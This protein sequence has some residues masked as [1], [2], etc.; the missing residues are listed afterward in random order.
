MVTMIKGLATGGERVRMIKIAQISH[1]P[2]KI[3]REEDA[4]ALLR[5]KDSLHRHGILVPLTVRPWEG[6][7]RLVA[8]ERRL[9]AARELGFTEVPCVVFP[10][11]DRLCAEFALIESIHRRELDMFSQAE[12]INNLIGTVGL[13]RE[14][15][16]RQLSCS[17]GCISNKLRLLRFDREER[18]AI[19]RGGLTER[20]ARAVLRLGDKSARLRMIERIARDGMSVSRTEELVEL[21]LSAAFDAVDRAS[22]VRERRFA[23][24]TASRRP[25]FSWFC[26][27]FSV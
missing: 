26:L 19:L 21:A 12:A 4:N 3:R 27:I 15:A 8:G 6:G 14:E 11:D 16:A 10:A 25:V 20:H 1:D 2:L 7:Y 24:Y 13:T 9:R 23:R 5:L 17:A 22:P 18:E